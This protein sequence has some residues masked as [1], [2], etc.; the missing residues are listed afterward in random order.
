MRVP[1][2]RFKV[3]Y[4]MLA[5]VIVALG[6][7]YLR[8]PYPVETT[9]VVTEIKDSLICMSI[10]SCFSDGRVQRVAARCPKG[11]TIPRDLKASE[12]WPEGR[13]HVGP[14]L[15]IEWSD[16]STSYYLEGR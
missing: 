12:P 8:R 6:F 3:W 15:R 2:V 1:R 4:I 10:T 9:W 5:V 13:S 11:G 14:F 7:G 16:G